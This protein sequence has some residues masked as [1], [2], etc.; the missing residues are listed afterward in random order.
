MNYVLSSAGLYS[1]DE[2]AESL[3]EMANKLVGWQEN[4]VVLA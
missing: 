2:W 1:V 4:W 3:A